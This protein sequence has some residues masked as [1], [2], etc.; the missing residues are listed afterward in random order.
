M[1]SSDLL[2]AIVVGVFVS[3][4]P[5]LYLVGTVFMIAALIVMIQGRPYWW[6]AAFLTPAI[7]LYESAGSTVS[8]V[9]TERL[10]ATLVGVAGTLLVML[11]LLPL[12]KR[13]RSTRGGDEQQHQQ[14]QQQGVSPE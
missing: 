2:I 11:I 4:G 7:V 5:V 14:H 12:A 8:K 13:Y 10:E 1:C 6:F 3:S 9:A